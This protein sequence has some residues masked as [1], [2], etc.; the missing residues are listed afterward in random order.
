MNRR[1]LLGDKVN[2]PFANLL[3][4]GVILITLGLGLRLILR[5]IGVWP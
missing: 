2:G 1:S 4:G 5:A 3:G